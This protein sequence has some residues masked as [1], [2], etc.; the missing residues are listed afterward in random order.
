M[1]IISTRLYPLLYSQIAKTFFALLIV[2]LIYVIFSLVSR[3]IT[4]KSIRERFKVRLFYVMTFIFLLLVIHTWLRGFGPIFAVIGVVFAAL[5]VT[6]KETIMNFTGFLIIQWRELFTEDDHIQIG[7]VNGVVKKIGILY[8]TILEYMPSSEKL[9]TGRV[10]YI[11]NAQVITG[12][13][14][15]YSQT[16]HFL[17]YH[18]SLVI[19][20]DSDLALAVET[21]QT[22]IQQVLTEHYQ[23]KPEYAKEYL[24]HKNK[25]Y[26]GLVDW[27]PFVDVSF[28]QDKPFGLKLRA[29]YYCY[30]IDHDVIEKTI[31]LAL[32]PALQKHTQVQLARVT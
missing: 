23:G 24:A 27:N 13:V 21:I 18:V 15:N 31:Y 17:A 19:T 20:P 14:T 5:I 29:N 8:L 28:H 11:P 10:M 2:T 32:I 12:Q 4:R 6:N 26:S 9:A 25:R 30:A 22:I 16:S 1:D 7:T 3:R